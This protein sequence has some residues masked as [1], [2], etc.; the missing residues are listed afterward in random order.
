MIKKAIYQYELA[1]LN[2][3]EF[4]F[5]DD[6][7]ENSFKNLVQS[8]PLKFLGIDVNQNETT[9]HAIYNKISIDNKFSITFLVDADYKIIKY[10]EDWISQIYNRTYRTFNSVDARKDGVLVLQR[11]NKNGEL[12]TIKSYSFLGC[13]P[14]SIN[15]IELNYQATD[16]PTITIDFICD[17]IEPRE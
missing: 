9:S 3:W 10:F 1:N 11:F 6:V 2:L 12:T 7:F 5:V 8:V 13:L 14:S 4:W 15:N 16:A 17:S